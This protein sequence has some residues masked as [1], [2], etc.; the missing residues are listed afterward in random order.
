M[1]GTFWP[2]KGH[3]RAW[4]ILWAALAT[5]DVAARWLG[6]ET[7]NVPYVLKLASDDLTNWVA[8][9]TVWSHRESLVQ[10]GIKRANDN[11][12]TK[13]WARAKNREGKVQQSW[14]PW[15]LML[16]LAWFPDV[17]TS[18]LKTVQVQTD[19]RLFL[20]LTL[21]LFIKIRQCLLP[22]KINKL[23]KCRD[24][25]KLSSLSRSRRKTIKK[26]QPAWI[27]ASSVRS[28]FMCFTLINLSSMVGAAAQQPNPWMS[29]KRRDLLVLHTHSPLSD[30]CLCLSASA[31]QRKS[32]RQRGAEWAEPYS[33]WGPGWVWIWDGGH[34][35]W[36][37]YW[38]SA[39]V[40]PVV[41]L[42]N[43]TGVWIIFSVEC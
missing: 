17:A 3:F 11:R 38:Y 4:M 31:L 5:S 32:I 37:L 40:L 14:F 16:Q 8:G 24:F 10:T 35:A 12:Q 25:R 41:F 13:V 36:K 26:H 19:F 43:R 39:G 28:S 15:S 9:D 20:S 23:T 7:G 18:A 29:V 34:V 27:S 21:L 30:S 22:D 6:V 1:T 42:L 2:I 33:Q